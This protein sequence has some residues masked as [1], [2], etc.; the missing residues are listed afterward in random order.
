MGALLA[1]LRAQRKLPLYVP[2]QTIVN[3]PFRSIRLSKW[4]DS[5]RIVGN[6]EVM[7]SAGITSGLPG[8]FN[9][10]MQHHL[11]TNLFKGGVYDPT[12]TVETFSRG[13]D[14]HLASME[15]RAV[16]ARDW[17]RFWQATSHHSQNIVA[18]WRHSSRRSSPLAVVTHPSGARRH[19]TRN[20][21]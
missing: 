19:L 5:W 3:A 2:P 1:L 8:A 10:S 4:I 17:A 9:G 16:P 18:L 21:L 7:A 12:K 13:K 6:P 15:V 11:G 20:R 14:R